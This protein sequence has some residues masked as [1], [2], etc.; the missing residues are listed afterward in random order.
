MR[1]IGARGPIGGKNK[2]IAS[3][4]FARTEQKIPF[5][6]FFTQAV[7]RCREEWNFEVKNRSMGAESIEKFVLGQML[8]N[9]AQLEVNRGDRTL[10]YEPTPAAYLEKQKRL[11]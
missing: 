2:S 7:K 11:E 9:K 10:R 1:S 4:L 5:E 3:S 6:E 8:R